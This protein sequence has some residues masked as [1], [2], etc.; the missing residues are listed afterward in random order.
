MDCEYLALL[1]DVKS[2]TLEN[3]QLILYSGNAGDRMFFNNGGQA[4]QKV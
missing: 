3:G 1:T 2:A 4:E